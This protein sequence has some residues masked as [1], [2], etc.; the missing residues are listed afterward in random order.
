MGLD[1]SFRG[2]YGPAPQIDIEKQIARARVP[3]P[4]DLDFSA[5][6]KEIEKNNLGIDG[7]IVLADVSVADGKV[8]FTGS[9]QTFPLT[10]SGEGGR[11]WLRVSDWADPSKTALQILPERVEP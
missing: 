7:I 2:L 5:L 4:M 1:R 3:S 10:G 8:T 11:R 6:L 9:N